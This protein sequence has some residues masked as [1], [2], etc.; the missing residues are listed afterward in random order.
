[1]KGTNFNT[2]TGTIKLFFDHPEGENFKFRV[3]RSCSIP[4][5]SIRGNWALAPYSRRQIW[6]WGSNFLSFSFNVS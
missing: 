2:N 6:L 4:C 5:R 3:R 1:M